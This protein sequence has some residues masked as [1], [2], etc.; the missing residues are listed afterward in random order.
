MSNIH[1]SDCRAIPDFSHLTPD[2]V[3]NAVEEV[4]GVRCSNLCRPLNSY[5]NR[6]YEVGLD[7]G[8]FDGLTAGGHVIAKF[9]RPGRWSRDALQDELDFLS[10]LSA[11]EVPVVPPLPGPDGKLLHQLGGTWFALEETVEIETVPSVFRST[12]LKV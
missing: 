11:A 6:V 5:I 10:E 8:G 4:L 2:T 7:A 9:Y 12:L 1:S 3:I